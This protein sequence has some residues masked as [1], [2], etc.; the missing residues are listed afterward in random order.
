MIGLFIVAGIII[1][2][3]LLIGY[4]VLLCPKT[5]SNVGCDWQD[6]RVIITWS[7]HSRDDGYQIRYRKK[8]NPNA[9]WYILQDLQIN[10]YP[11]SIVNGISY[12]IKIK[13]KNSFGASFLACTVSGRSRAP[14]PQNLDVSY[15]ANKS[16]SISLHWTTVTN[17]DAYIIKRTTCLESVM[18]TY[19]MRIDNST[20]TNFEDTSFIFGIKYCYVIV[21]LDRAGESGQSNPVSVFP[22]APP[23]SDLIVSYDEYTG[24]SIKLQWKPVVNCHGYVIRRET[25]AFLSN[26]QMR[27]E[28]RSYTD[29][30]TMLGN[31]CKKP[32]NTLILMRKINCSE[33]F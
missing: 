4:K 1:V 30:R 18:F 21:S 11:L 27:I 25:E 22:Q 28:Y 3:G 15:S 19:V 16:N 9:E 2:F 32:C 5:P 7:S 23:P 8:N 12:E 14:A 33:F 13:A 20:I 10:T 6:A 31:L 17:C 29:N 26:E 24:A